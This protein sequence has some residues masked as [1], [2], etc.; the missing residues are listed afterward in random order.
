MRPASTLASR[1]QNS[2]RG[3][4]WATFFFF[5]VSCGMFF[6]PQNTAMTHI[7]DTP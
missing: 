4:D 2:N 3:Q 6:A 5:T 1:M 7:C